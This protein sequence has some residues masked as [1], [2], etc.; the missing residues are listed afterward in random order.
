MRILLLLALL[1]GTSPA[2][3]ARRGA[4]QNLSFEKDIRPIFRAHCYDCHGAAS[5]IKGKLDLRLVRFITAGGETGPAI[6]PGKPA[7]SFLVERIKAGEMPPGDT[8]VNSEEIALIEKWIAQGALTSHPEPEQIPP[9]LGISFEER[10]YWAYQPITRPEVPRPRKAGR[11]RNEIDA[12]LLARMQD[13]KLQFSAD[14]DRLTLA[15]RVY[16]DLTGLPPSLQQVQQFI[17]DERPNAYELLVDDLLDSPHYGERWGRH[18]LDVAGY[19]DS[20]GYSNEDPERPYSYKYRNYV[21]QSFNDDLPFDQFIQ[22][23]LAGDEMVT[24]PLKNMSAES[25]R[26]LTATGFLRMGVDGTG[27]ENNDASRNQVLADTIKIVSSSL[28]GMSVGCARCHDHRYDPISH[29]DY[30]RL[31]AIFE[32]AFDWKNWRTPGG[33]QISLYTDVDA[34]RRNEVN[35]EAAVLEKERDAKQAEYIQIALDK[36]FEQYEE[37]VRVQLQE[38]KKTAADKR[39]AEQKKLLEDQPNLNVSAGNLYQYNQGHADKIKEYNTRV[40]EIK[41]KIPIEE[42][43]R[44]TTEPGSEIP[45]TF[46]FYR[47]DHRQPQQQVVPGGLTITAAEGKRL[48]IEENNADLSSSGRRLAYARWLTSGQHPTVARVLVNRVWLHHFGRGIVETPGE[49]GKLGSLPTHPQL[50]DWLASSFMDSG[51]SL[52]QLHR[53]IVTSTAYRQSSVRDAG[54]D[55]VD[56]ANAYYWHKSVQRLDAEIVRDRMLAVSGQLDTTMYGAADSITADDSGKVSAGDSRRRSIYI[57]VRRTQP[58]ALL[59]AFD[60][61]VMAVNCEKRSSSTVASQSLMLMNGD[62]ILSAASALAARVDEKAGGQVDPA[63]VEGLQIDFDAESYAQLRTPWRYGYGFISEAA[64]GGIAPV[65]FTHYPLY[66]DGYWKGGKELPDPTLGYSFL[67]AGGGHP[68]NITQRPIRRWI[69]PVTGKLTIKGSLNHSSE[70]GDGVRL[71]VY[72]SRLGAQGSWDAAGSS[73]EYSVSLEVQRGDF[74]DTIVDERTGNNSD[75]F[76]NSYTI[77]LANENG[78]DGKTWHSEKDFHG[79]IEEKVIVIKSPIIEQAVYAWQLAYC[80]T[81]TRE[82]VELSARHIETQLDL[83]M[84]QGHENPVLQAMANYCQALLGS[85]EFLYAE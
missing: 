80:R 84:D 5:E 22:E 19:A 53:L 33:R 6:V 36:E 31:R 30:H 83:L 82:E 64:E 63:L 72:S 49:F 62:F 52:K 14:A 3:A 25:I 74:I 54:F 70:N 38:A 55:R 42:F 58:V 67:I 66:A 27:K 15:K 10:A 76:S 7:E 73:Q 71:T 60:A 13:K 81:P 75:S 56:A 41:K 23:Q 34:A 48:A 11:V 2:L 24:P 79:P 85:N 44:V 20:E 4:S 26:M 59:Q 29:V 45:K 17:E 51:W 40:G 78:S 12:F 16:L 1:L 39:S 28:L 32:P 47:G 65:N 50:L 21:I 37:A 77:T 69:S 9:G 8:R 35:Q 46:L 18:W 57:Q 68:N 61:P 43:L